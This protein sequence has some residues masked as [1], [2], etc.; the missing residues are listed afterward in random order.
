MWTNEVLKIFHNIF[1]F[2]GLNY[3]GTAKSTQKNYRKFL[4]LCVKISVKGR[5]L[6][7]LARF[8]RKDPRILVGHNLSKW[9]S[10]IL[11]YEI[12]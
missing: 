5:L 2:R 1:S 4:Q 7:S 12:F 10:V 8:F 9:A 3:Y 6:F 11:T